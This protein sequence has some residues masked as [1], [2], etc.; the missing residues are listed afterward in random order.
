MPDQDETSVDSD[1]IYM[2]PWELLRS[3]DFD[4][5]LQIM[6]EEWEWRPS[7]RY[8]LRLGIGYMWAE[9]YESA[10]ELFT[11]AAR[12]QG[13]GEHD[14]ALAGVAD[15]HLGNMAAAIQFWREG[16]KAQYAVGC[17][18]CS[19]TARF[20]IVASALEPGRFPKQQAE[21][22]LLDAMERIG[23]SRWSGVLGRFLLGQIEASEVEAH[24]IVDRSV[25]GVLPYRIWLTDF[26]S[27]A[28]RLNHTEIDAPAFRSL[29]R[30]L[31]DAANSG[32]TDTGAFAEL[33]RNPE[34]FFARTEAAKSR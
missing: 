19:M 4:Q 10:S 21:R 16:L 8:R 20:L 14:F 9:M 17:R 12:S 23:P 27:A 3:G 18:V 29:M 13:N 5:G 22:I 30:P 25:K 33:L 1:M 28:R 6:R 7:A 32:A 15:W 24:W 2:K 26:Y 34:Y 11:A 31:A